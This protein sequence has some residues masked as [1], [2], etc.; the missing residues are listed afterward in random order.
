MTYAWITTI[1][2]RATFTLALSSAGC[3]RLGPTA[4]GTCSPL[5]DNL[6]RGQY[7]SKD[8]WPRNNDGQS[9]LTEICQPR[10]YDSI[11]IGENP[12]NKVEEEVTC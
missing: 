5:P 1:T 4:E 10:T 3:N 8:P 7:S 12:V 11:C 2:V 6:H 9:E